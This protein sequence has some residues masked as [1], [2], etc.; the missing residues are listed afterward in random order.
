[1]RGRRQVLLPALDRLEIRHTQ[2]E[3]A[4]KALEELIT[5]TKQDEG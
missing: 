2:A 5:Q 3:A 1:M 4:K